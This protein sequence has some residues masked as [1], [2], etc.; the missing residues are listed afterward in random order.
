MGRDVLNRGDEE[1]SIGSINE[2]NRIYSGEIEFTNSGP[3]QFAEPQCS[4]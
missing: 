2:D 1:N 4:S 3:I